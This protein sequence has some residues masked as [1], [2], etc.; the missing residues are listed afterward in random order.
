MATASPAQRRLGELS[1]PAS[2]WARE[3]VQNA[4]N[5]GLPPS[6]QMVSNLLGQRAEPFPGSEERQLGL[7]KQGECC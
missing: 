7:R 3:K 4:V 2:A 1:L 6:V 5:T